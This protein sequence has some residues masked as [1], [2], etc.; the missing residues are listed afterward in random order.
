MDGKR[1]RHRLKR[2][3]GAFTLIEL[4]VVIAIIAV[5]AA[6]L[7]PALG[8]AKSS[9]RRIECGNNL[10]QLAMALALYASD[11]AASIPPRGSTNR[12]P[13]QLKPHY[14]NLRVLRCPR[15][16]RATDPLAVTNTAPDLAAR[17]FLLN[18]FQ[19]LYSPERSPLPKGQPLS[20]LRESDIR[21]PVETILFGE[22]KSESKQFYVLLDTAGAYLADLEESRHGGREGPGN[23]SGGSNYAFADSHVSLL[24]YGKSLCPLNLWAITAEGRIRHAVCRAPE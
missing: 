1:R 24:R 8:R 4:L 7:L 19:D 9:A 20:P 5:L 21:H 3:G 17:S 6:L 18:G 15:D 10:R 12:W 11:N 13:A 2:H 16:P 14:S 22:K 23:K